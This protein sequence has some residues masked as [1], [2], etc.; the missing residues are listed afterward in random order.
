M[1]LAA[2][3]TPRP[4]ANDQVSPA[5]APE[6]SLGIADVAYTFDICTYMAGSTAARQYAD[7][8]THA[9]AAFGVLD[10]Q[11]IGNHARDS[12][13]HLI[14][15]RMPDGTLVG[16]MRVHDRRRGP[17]PLELALAHLPEVRAHLDQYILP[18]ELSGTAVRADWRKSALSAWLVRVAV[19]A[20]P[21]L[22]AHA[23]VGFGHQ[24]I[25]PLYQ[26]FGFLPVPS[27]PAVAYP[28]ER[29]RSQVAAMGDV[30]C[31]DHLSEE[32]R[33]HI[34]KLRYLLQHAI[35]QSS[36]EIAA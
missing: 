32:E 5:R 24:R 14:L 20:L 16:G 7:L 31:L 15:A 11:R 18:F 35:A 36:H 28:D 25:L 30:E 19:A 17:L 3:P 4:I 33:S 34:L 9:Y 29:Y 6:I 1:K 2:Y 26:R 22:G 13:S 10:A 21:Y 23:S 8:Q 27:L 12:C